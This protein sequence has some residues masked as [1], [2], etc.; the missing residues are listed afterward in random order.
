MNLPVSPLFSSQPTLESPPSSNSNKRLLEEGSSESAKRAKQTTEIA[1]T[2]LSE[3]SALSL[4]TSKSTSEPSSEPTSELTSDP[5]IYKLIKEAESSYSCKSYEK[6]SKIV[7]KALKIEPANISVLSFLA[8]IQ[9]RQNKFQSSLK[10]I[11]ETLQICPTHQATL[12]VRAAINFTKKNFSA[13]F[14]DL[15]AIL[16]TN[17]SHLT[18]LKMRGKAYYNERQFDLAL[19]D[20]T[21]AASQDLKALKTFKTLASIYVILKDPSNALKYFNFALTVNPKHFQCLKGRMKI[22]QELGK[23]DLALTDLNECLQQEPLHFDLLKMRIELGSQQGLQELVLRDLKQILYHEPEN[24]FANLFLAKIFIKQN[25]FG[26]ALKC[27]ELLLKND[28]SDEFLFWH[29]SILYKN[30]QHVEAMTALKLL[31]KQNPNIVV[32]WSLCAQILETY[33]MLDDALDCVKKALSLEPLNP[34]ALRIRA[35]IYRKMGNWQSALLDLEVVLDKIP[36]DAKALSVQAEILKSFTPDAF[37]EVE[38]MTL[39]EDTRK[40]IKERAKKFHLS[41]NFSGL[42]EHL[43]STINETSGISWTNYKNIHSIY[44]PRSLDKE[45]EKCLQPIFESAV[46]QDALYANFKIPPPL[47]YLSTP[48]APIEMSNELEKFMLYSQL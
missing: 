27:I 43:E 14:S 32:G 42:L 46:A 8:E 37:E 39:S 15:N 45:L 17:P 25:M 2:A 20:L 1:E 48:P 21:L 38:K 44:H 3:T 16:S 24:F 36:K 40:F 28:N 29:A 18:A 12:L 41:G 35:N 47:Q 33:F 9:Y 11:Q 19:S 30:Q 23:I 34:L 13:V 6:S 22:Y 4:P 7:K 26:D 5:R 31:F 10:T